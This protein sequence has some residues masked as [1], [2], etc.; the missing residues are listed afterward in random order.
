ML[1]P[2]NF[3]QADDPSGLNVLYSYWYQFG[4]LTLP[5]LVVSHSK[6][7]VD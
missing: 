4:V 3:Q 1:L 6:V 2:L 7:F 5:G